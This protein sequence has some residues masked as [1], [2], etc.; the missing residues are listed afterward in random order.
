MGGARVGGAPVAGGAR[1]GGG[2][3][4]RGGGFRAPSIGGR[5]GFRGPYFGGYYGGGFGYY[6]LYNSAYPNYYD[7]YPYGSYGDGAPSYSVGPA[8][9]SYQ[10]F[11][12]QTIDTT[13]A[14]TSAHFTVNV[15]ADAQVWFD[16][17]AT[18]STGTVRQFTSPPLTPGNRHSYEVRA[19]WNEN[20]HEVSQSRQVEV[21]AGSDVSLSFYSASPKTSGPAEAVK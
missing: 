8:I 14:D 15:P 10:S 17:T 21:A 3:F 5:G 12:P 19:R 1:I 9:G 11:Y 18:T 7:T 16:G 6:P 20:G 2:G 13:P 4:N